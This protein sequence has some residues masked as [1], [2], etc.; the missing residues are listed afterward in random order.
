[1]ARSW[2]D[3]PLYR[4]FQAELAN[5]TDRDFERHALH[6][7]RLIWPSIVGTPIR[8]FFDRKGIDHLVWTDHPPFPVVVQCKGWEVLE[9]ELGGSQV[10]QCIDS[11]GTFRESGFEAEAYILVHNRLGANENF[12]NPIETHLN[13]LVVS[14]QVK[15]A[16]L[17][18]RQKLV[19]QAFRILYERCLLQISDRNLS[20]YKIFQNI[21]QS[22]GNPLETV[23]LKSSLLL[24]DQYH[25]I[26]SEPTKSMVADPCNELLLSN[27]KISLLVGQAGFGKSTT[28]FRLSNITGHKTIYVPATIFTAV[29]T[30]SFIRQAISIDEMLKD[31]LPEDISIH[32]EIAVVVISQILKIKETPLLL[33][34]DGLD[35]SIYFNK[36]GGIQ[37]LLNIISDIEVP[38]VL[39]ARSE[40]WQEKEIDFATQFGDVGP[41]KRRN[42]IRFI[43]LL[44]WSDDKIL[45]LILQIKSKVKN[46]QQ[47]TRIAKLEELTKNGKYVDY[48]GDIPRRPLFLKFI[49]ETILQC[50][51]HKVNKAQLFYEWACQ[52]ILRDIGNPKQ[53]G[54][55]RVPIASQDESAQSTVEL[56]F[57]AMRNAAA[58]MTQIDENLVEMVP[59]CTLAKLLESHS[60]LRQIADP[61]GIVLNSLLISIPTELGEEKRISFAHRT[62]QE[63]F[64]AQAIFKHYADFGQAKLPDSIQEW[65]KVLEM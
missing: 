63:Y 37:E 10:K 50:D 25:L 13:G 11:I 65:I 44:P 33:I 20:N 26:D 32:K 6:F 58:L 51:P 35:E 36:R 61:T 64:L 59:S 62:F 29:N 24:A 17:W 5:R 22:W 55:Q 2:T 40:Y 28:A 48:Y 19:Q 4:N 7:L 9:E 53:F 30:H 12:R 8:K 60:R 15:K 57:I 39:T 16:E 52:K 56:A 34:I 38:I 18:S 54:G 14:G 47:L 41:Q 1:M 27:E 49:L 43:E 3:K 23:P 46:K 45:E 21:E 42:K 31:S